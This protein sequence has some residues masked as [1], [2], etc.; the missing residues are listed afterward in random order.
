M[1]GTGHC[2][3]LKGLTRHSLKAI[4]ENCF[5]LFLGLSL[6]FHLGQSVLDHLAS[7]VRL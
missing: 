1:V 3:G 6:S 5:A 4:H 2:L 7:S